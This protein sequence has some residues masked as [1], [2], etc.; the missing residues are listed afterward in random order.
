MEGEVEGMEEEKEVI[1]EEGRKRGAN[2]WKM[3][4][5]ILK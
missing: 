3:W 2:G 5:A 1:E 4:L